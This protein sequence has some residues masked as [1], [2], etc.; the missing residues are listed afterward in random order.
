LNNGK[1]ILILVT[2]RGLGGDAINALNVY[3]ALEERGFN[4]ELALDKTAPGFLFKK[5]NIP[6][7]KVSI[8]QAGGHAATKLTALKAAFR[9]I[10]AVYITRKL[11][12]KL[13]P[14]LVM[15]IIGGGAIIAAVSAKIS[16]VPSVNLLDTPLDTKVCKKLGVPIIMPENSLFTQELPSYMHKVFFASNNDVDKGNRDVA[17]ENI[18]RHCEEVKKDNPDAIEF[19]P[20]KKTVFF[21]SGSAL[22]EKT[23][24]AV[25]LFSKNCDKYN[26][27]I[28]GAPLEEEFS[29]YLNEERIINLGY[30]NWVSDLY[31]LADVAVFSDD[32]LMVQEAMAFSLPTVLL[33]RVKYNRY[34]NM[35]SVF[36]GATIECDLDD[37][38]ESV[39]YVFDHYDD[40]KEKTNQYKKDILRVTDDICDIV[41]DTLNKK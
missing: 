1:T 36:K 22:F 38:E 8:P 35:A 28:I 40:F 32:G 10:K 37:L 29:K 4:C 18:M 3:N 15:G 25:D 20:S 7:H 33:K 21:S 26:I 23:A 11:I 31:Y 9:A 39:Q 2:G 19:D 41:E 14:D 24:Q 6:W 13:K 5:N 34:H 12:R 30:I 17:I 16:R 27:V